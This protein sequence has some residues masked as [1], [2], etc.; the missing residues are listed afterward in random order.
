MFGKTSRNSKRLRE[1]LRA[2]S[3][4]AQNCVA[5]QPGDAQARFLK[6]QSE[7]IGSKFALAK[8]GVPGLITKTA[9][10][11]PLRSD[12]H[13]FQFSPDGK[14]MLAQ[15]DNSVFVL[16]ANPVTNLFTIDA[17]DTYQAQFT[18]DSRGIV[19]YDKELRVEKWDIEKQQRS[20]IYQVALPGECLGT[21]LSHPGEVLACVTAQSEPELI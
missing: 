9:L 21:T 4:L 7:V 10:N 2:S 8:E 20:S 19:F 16:S 6:W 12:L 17:P 5:P 3:P 18:P 11:P 1:L 15:D 14:Y 13:A